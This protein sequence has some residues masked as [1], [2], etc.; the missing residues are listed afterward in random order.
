MQFGTY[1][2]PP[3]AL[4]WIIP[5]LIWELIWK[6]IG[7]WHAARNSQKWWFVAILI[8][9]TIGLLPIVYLVFFNKKHKA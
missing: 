3:Y 8:L 5:L 9:N 7:L 1:S 4:L 2:L 6:G